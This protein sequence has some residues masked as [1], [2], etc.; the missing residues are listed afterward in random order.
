MTCA[1]IRPLL[2]MQIDGEA[3]AGQRRAVASHL[4]TCPA[5]GATLRAIATDDRLLAGAWRPIVAPAT[6]ASRVMAALPAP[7]APPAQ[8]LRPRRLPTLALAAALL[9]AAACAVAVPV[10]VLGPVT[11]RETE[12]PTHERL[13]DPG[14]AVELDTARQRVPW[15][16]R[17]PRALPAGYRLIAVTVGEVHEGNDTTVVLH[18]RKGDAPDGPALRIT[19]LRTAGRINEPVAPGAA[20]RIRVGGRDAL[21]IDGSW[22]ER[23]GQSV[24]VPGSLLRLILEDGDLV[25]QLEGEPRD[26]W[27]ARGLQRVGASLR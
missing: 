6:F 26:G 15:R 1:E 25:I 21:L 5:C 24:W 16:V 11:V 19:E 10:L 13:I 12:R 23:D 7:A 4:A 18:Y 3:T 14:A 22:Q 2:S 17:T 9:L 20:S 27:D 8:R